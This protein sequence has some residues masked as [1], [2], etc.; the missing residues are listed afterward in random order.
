MFN[1]QEPL[2]DTQTTNWLWEVIFTGVYLKNSRKKF[3]YKSLYTTRTF[4]Q[5]S[6][7]LTKILLIKFHNDANLGR[8]WDLYL[9]YIYIELLSDVPMN[10]LCVRG[11]MFSKPAEVKWCRNLSHY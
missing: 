4:I 9:F 5:T 1:S 8:M 3:M 7:G 11:T 10:D 2:Q 6:S